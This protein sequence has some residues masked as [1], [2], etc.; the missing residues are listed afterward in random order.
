[1]A[2][3]LSVLARF[4]RLSR[5]RR[6]RTGPQSSGALSQG[7]HLSK[8]HITYIGYNNDMSQSGNTDEQLKESD[9]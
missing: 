4:L 3:P 9:Q 5:L 6:D 1:M 2:F 7:D 8:S